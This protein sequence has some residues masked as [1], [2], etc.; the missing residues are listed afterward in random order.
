MDFVPILVRKWWNL[1]KHDQTCQPPCSAASFVHHNNRVAPA[2][3]LFIHL[4]LHWHLQGFTS[5]AVNVEKW[6]MASESN[7]K[8]QQGQPCAVLRVLSSQAAGVSP[9]FSCLFLSTDLPYLFFLFVW[10]GLFF[11][12]FHQ[13]F[14]FSL[15]GPWST[16]YSFAFF[17]STPSFQ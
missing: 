11:P 8:M 15:L 4:Y 10:S 3:T 1:K 16:T 9:H 2:W 17:S 13:A 7:V 5:A 6:G 12:L 14:F